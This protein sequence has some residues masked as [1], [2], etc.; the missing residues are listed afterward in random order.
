MPKRRPELVAAE[1]LGL[2][3]IHVDTAHPT[4]PNPHPPPQTDR[5][6][7]TART[8]AVPEPTAPFPGRRIHRCRRTPC[9]RSDRHSLAT[10]HEVGGGDLENPRD[11]KTACLCWEAVAWVVSSRS[12]AL[13]VD[14]LQGALERGEIDLAA[15]QTSSGSDSSRS[16]ML[17]AA[18]WRSSWAVESLRSW[19]SPAAWRGSPRP[20]VW[21]IMCAGAVLRRRLPRS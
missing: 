14:L 13:V 5:P 18:T 9:T 10:Q 6:V 7:D 8:T 17:W 21:L 3:E 1:P 20:D 11:R 12:L 15:L 16:W 2:S 19:P 4:P